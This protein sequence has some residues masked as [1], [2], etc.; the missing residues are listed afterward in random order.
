MMMQI[1]QAGGM[2]ILTDH[3]RKA[4]D[5]NPKGYYELERAKKLKEGDI[6]W[7][8]DARGKAVKIIS[9]LLEHLPPD[10]QYKV[11]FMQRSMVEVLASQKQ[12]LIR[13]GE[14][15]EKTSDETLA[16][17]FEKHLTQ[18]QA[19]LGEQANIE[20]LYVRYD[21][22]LKEPE[23]TIGEIIRFLDLPLDADSMLAVPDKRLYRQRQ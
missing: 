17:L 5:D 15:S 2:E 14:D 10:Y 21:E 23:A 12:M 9:A 1:L 8:K 18:V 20:V 19:W 11:V 4:D 6:G 13:R 3:E 7:V 16:E 22:L